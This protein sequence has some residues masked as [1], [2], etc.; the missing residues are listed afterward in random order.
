[1][2]EQLKTLKARVQHK[3]KT[4][5]NW[6]K[7][8]Y[9]DVENQVFQT[10]VFRPL[11]GELIIYDRDENYNYER[12]K[13]GRQD[14]D[15]AEGV[16]LK[17]HLLEFV[18][19]LTNISYAMQSWSEVEV[20][21]TYGIYTW[22]GQTYYHGDE[23]EIGHHELTTRLPLAAGNN[24]VFDV[25]RR[26]GDQIMVINSETRY[27]KGLVYES[28]EDGNYWIVTG[29]GTCTDEEL[30]IPS[31]YYGLPV[32]EIGDCVF[33]GRTSLTSVVIPDSITSIHYEAFLDC[34]SL[35]SIVI[36]DS[37]TSIGSS[38]FDGCTSLTSVVIGNSVTSIGDYA[39]QYCNSLTSVVIPDSVTS[40]GN[41]AFYGC[42]LL[43]SIVIPDSVTSIGE[44][45]F[46]DCTNLKNVYYKGSEESW[47]NIEIGA[48]N[49]YLIDATI[50][51]N[52]VDDFIG[53][54]EKIESSGVPST[55]ADN[56][57]KVLITNASG[58][59]EWQEPAG[60]EIDTSNLATVDKISSISAEGEFS[61]INTNNGL[62][63]IDSSIITI[64]IN[65]YDGIQSRNRV[66]IVAGSNVAFEIDETNQVVKISV[67]AIG[68]ISTALDSII[69]QTNAII[70]GTE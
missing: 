35:T 47:N 67:P 59:P 23:K 21:P 27:S 62:S 70:G 55:S 66:P 60:G 53:I 69:T 34:T 48:N 56:A 5:A 17:L 19:D 22:G 16:G 58:I 10:N 46:Y 26:D 51:Y 64:D 52:Y 14:P 68:D 30:I 44:Y 38:A 12:Y 9:S 25:E 29:I 31:T 41:D 45:A 13:I 39:F 15:E 37:V 2:S 4:E 11:P 36:P 40:I 33:S 28:P 20:D 42:D 65:D 7:D 57:G 1:M 61:E 18:P 49:D 6:L 54:N 8:I 3:H 32:K 50:H 24:I 43:T 63:W